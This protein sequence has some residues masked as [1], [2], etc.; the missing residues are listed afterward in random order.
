MTE[1]PRQTRS[2]GPRSAHRAIE[3]REKRRR[4]LLSCLARTC[5][6]Y[7]ARAEPER[8]TSRRAH[9]PAADAQN[10]RTGAGK[11]ELQPTRLAAQS[12]GRPGTARSAKQ[13]PG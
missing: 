13:C 1:D 2:N 5:Q 7:P 6:A 9:Y 10:P 12:G 8:R 11:G 3:I 4:V